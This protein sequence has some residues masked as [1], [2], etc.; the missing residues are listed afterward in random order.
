MVSNFCQGFSLQNGYQQFEKG[1]FSD[2]FK[3]KFFQVGYENQICEIRA[4]TVVSESTF[5]P[6]D[7][8]DNHADLN[9]CEEF[10]VIDEWQQLQQSF[11]SLVCYDNNSDQD[12]F[13]G[14]HCFLN[15]TDFMQRKLQLLGQHKLLLDFKDPNGHLLGVEMEQKVFCL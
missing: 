15:E 3:S 14:Y 5:L 10:Y 13:R 12:L 4:P 2:I 8:Y 6:F 7:C 1:C 11:D 9:F